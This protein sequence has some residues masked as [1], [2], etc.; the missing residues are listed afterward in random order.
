VRSEYVE[1]HKTLN[2]SSSK[3]ERCT[4]PVRNK[5]GGA[6][7]RRGEMKEVFTQTP[8]LNTRLE[9]SPKGAF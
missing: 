1:L 9:Y 6:P 8:L 4:V 3:C 7:F 5:G 2:V